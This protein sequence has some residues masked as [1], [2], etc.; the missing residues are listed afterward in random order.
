MLTSVSFRF[1]IST[2]RTWTTEPQQNVQ[3]LKIFHLMLSLCLN[4]RG[5]QKYQFKR[6]SKSNND[7][8][9][10][11]TLVNKK[12]HELK[13]YTCTGADPGF[14]VR[15]RRENIWGISCEKSRFYAKKILFFPIL[16]CARRVRPPGSPLLS[17]QFQ[18]QIENEYL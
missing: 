17:K 3:K 12:W 11:S 6:V 5:L 8:I 1:L 9:S 10:I 13:Y 18:N 16:G 2:D 15:G 14:Q 4:T 7:L